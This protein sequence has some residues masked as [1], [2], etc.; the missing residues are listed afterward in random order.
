MYEQSAEASKP[1][2]K[3]QE[4]FK[5]K[6]A[7]FP[8]QPIGF[9]KVGEDPNTGKAIWKLHNPDGSE[10]Q[11]RVA[12]TQQI[13]TTEPETK[14]YTGQKQISQYGGYGNKPYFKRKRVVDM[15]VVT[16]LAR[17][18]ELLAK[19]WDFET[20]Y[21]ATLSNIPHHILVKKE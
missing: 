6:S 11:H 12:G 3:M 17:A 14:Q 13:A 16:E 18:K 20:S 2:N 4:C 15:E 21:P 9:E 19:G 10:H 7:G 1:Q 8:Q 5:C